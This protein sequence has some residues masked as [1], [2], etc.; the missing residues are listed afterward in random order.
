MTTIHY[1]GWTEACLLSNG[2]AEAVVVPAIGRIMQFRLAGESDGPF[3]ENRALDGRKPDPASTEWGN[4]G[5]D[6]SWPAPQDDW[7]KVTPRVWPPP[8]AFDSMPV[9]AA[10]SADGA[11]VLKSPVDPHYGIRVVRHITLAPGEPRMTVRTVFQKVEGAPATVSVWVVTQLEHPAAMFIPL[12]EE[13]SMAGGFVLLG[14]MPHPPSVR[15]DG[16]LLSMHRDAATAYKIGTEAERLLWVGGTLACRI[17][18]TR[19]AGAV[20]PDHGSS[21]EIYTNPDPLPYIELETLGPLN[22]LRVGEE[23]A[24]A[25]TYTLHR[26]RETDAAHEARRVLGLMP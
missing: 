14:G 9:E 8:T 6:K 25:N 1:H 20:H 7:P 19:S 3:W 24:Q 10:A 12:P 16:R 17:D 26:R 22:I 21:A 15:T 18:T 2:H 13:T 11:L 4:F 5:G 23:I